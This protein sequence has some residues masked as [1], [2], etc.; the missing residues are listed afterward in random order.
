MLEIYNEEI[1]INQATRNLKRGIYLK[2]WVTTIGM[3]EMLEFESRFQKYHF[4]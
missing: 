1:E 2:R 4:Q 3:S